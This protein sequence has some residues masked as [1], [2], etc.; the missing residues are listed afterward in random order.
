MWISA[1]AQ[2]GVCF[3]KAKSIYH[4]SVTQQLHAFVILLIGTSC[5]TICSF[6]DKRRCVYLFIRKPNWGLRGLL[7]NL[8]SVQISAASCVWR[9]HWWITINRIRPSI[10][11][12]RVKNWGRRFDQVSCV[13]VHWMHWGCDRLDYEA[14]SSMKAEVH[15]M[16]HQYLCEY[17]GYSWLYVFRCTWFISCLPWP[18]VLCLTVFIPP[19]FLNIINDVHSGA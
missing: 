13:T 1:P 12:Y 19:Q 5:S 18:C 3:R 10:F 11:H 14:C 16:Y 7:G 2:E 6:P 8:P 4:F 15:S 17:V 9:W